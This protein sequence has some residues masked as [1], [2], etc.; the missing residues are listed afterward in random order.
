MR[1][2]LVGCLCKNNLQIISFVQNDVICTINNNKHYINN[3]KEKDKQI[4]NETSNNSFNN[5]KTVLL[6]SVVEKTETTMKLQYFTEASVF[7]GFFYTGTRRSMG[8]KLELPTLQKERKE[9]IIFRFF[10]QIITKSTTA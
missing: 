6:Q 1:T 8:K 10:K 9:S 3:C 7:W 5:C 2:P 4:I